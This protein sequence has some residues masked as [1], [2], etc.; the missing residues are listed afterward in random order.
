MSVVVDLVESNDAAFTARKLLSSYFSANRFHRSLPFFIRT[1]YMD[2]PDC[3]Q[4]LLS[5]SVFTF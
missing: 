5:M 4:L 2:S 1:D 3:L